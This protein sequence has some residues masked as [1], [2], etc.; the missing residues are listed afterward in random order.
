MSR[1][2]CLSVFHVGG[3]IALY[4]SDN[5]TFIGKM[6][7][8]GGQ[9]SAVG[10]SNGQSGGAG[11][12]YA[13]HKDHIHRTLIVDNNFIPYQRNRDEQI[14]SY[15]LINRDGCVT[16]L[17]PEALDHEHSGNNSYDFE[18]LQVCHRFLSTLD[19]LLTCGNARC[20]ATL[21]LP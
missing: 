21:T 10:A 11:T 15:S 16:W 12:V 17:L 8:Y 3:R 13:Y 18:E 14:E 20:G 2:Q 9:A 19:A 5:S 7:A 1:D 6:S 4:F